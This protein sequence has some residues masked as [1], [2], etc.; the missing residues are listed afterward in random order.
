MKLSSNHS[1]L[2]LQ[3]GQVPFT[4]KCLKSLINNSITCCFL[5]RTL[6]LPSTPQIMTKLPSMAFR[7]LID[8]H[9]YPHL[10]LLQYSTTQWSHPPL[11]EAPLHT[12]PGEVVSIGR[13]MA[14]VALI[15]MRRVLLSGAEIHPQLNPSVMH[16]VYTCSN[17][18]NFDLKSSLMQM[19]TEAHRRNQTQTMLDLNAVTAVLI[20]LLFGEGAKPE[21]SFVMHVVCML[22]FGGSLGLYRSRETKFDHDL[23][24]FPSEF[25]SN[26]KHFFIAS[27]T[28]FLT[29]WSPTLTSLDIVAKWTRYI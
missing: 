29:L 1:I 2:E 13:N 20:T 17:E 24:T 14:E 8:S 5:R 6:L 28:C 9:L 11:L 26:S 10:L 3:H 19:M 18:I 15:V 7:F 27:K 4:S 23:N 22:A 16:V 21:I 12:V 25:L